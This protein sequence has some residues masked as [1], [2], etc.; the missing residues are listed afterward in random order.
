MQSHTITFFLRERKHGPKKKK[1]YTM[2]H[3]LAEFGL[4]ISAAFDNWC[5]RTE[6]FTI[7]N[8][9]EYVV[10]KDPVNLVC[11][12]DYKNYIP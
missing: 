8:F 6:D 9:C 2:L 4:D 7:E 12:P 1:Q 11:K 3:N 5:A 10:S